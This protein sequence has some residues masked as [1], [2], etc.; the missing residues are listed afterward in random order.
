MS[1][2]FFSI[3]L[4]Q[5]LFCRQS[6]YLFVNYPHIW[7]RNTSSYKPIF[8]HPLLPKN[9]F[10]LMV[11]YWQLWVWLN[12]VYLCHLANYFRLIWKKT[13]YLLKPSVTS[14]FWSVLGVDFA[15]TLAADKLGSIRKQSYIN[16]AIKHWPALLSRAVK[17]LI[18]DYNGK[19]L[20]LW[21]FLCHMVFYNAL[22]V[23]T[24]TS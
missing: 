16:P 24:L 1:P 7:K 4:K 11:I 13:Q 9:Q 6:H 23:M 2:L 3:F 14:Y 10:I 12:S 19:S 22:F 21:F 5:S 15:M 8:I 17:L 18:W 20:S